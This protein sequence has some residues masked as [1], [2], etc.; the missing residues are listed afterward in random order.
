[1]NEENLIDKNIFRLISYGVYIVT[2]QDTKKV[3]CVINTLTQVSGTQ[4]PIITISLNKNNYT[5]EVIRKTKKFAVSILAESMNPQVIKTFGFSSSRE[6]DKFE[7]VSYEEVEGIP[8]L[9]E[10]VCGYLL[11]ELV[12]IVETETHD[13]FVARV[14]RSTVL[15][16][17]KPMTYQY[18][19]DVVKGSAPKSAPSYVEEAITT[20]Q[21][22]EVWVCE[23]CGYVHYGPIEEGFTCPRCGV[24]QS[25]FQKQS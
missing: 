12:D 19:H 11:C 8:V 15:N 4:N 20:S 1:M 23:V 24:D 22:Q 2:C 16:D 9:N 13:L 5:N 18:Y 6:Q 25:H 17:L 7:S 21:D 3:G 14:V 10:Q